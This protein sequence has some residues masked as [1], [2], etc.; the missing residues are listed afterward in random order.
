MDAVDRVRQD[1]RKKTGEIVLPRAVFMQH[2]QAHNGQIDFPIR[3]KC[4]ASWSLP[5]WSGGLG[6]EAAICTG[7]RLSIEPGKRR[8]LCIVW[9]K[10]RIF[11][12]PGEG[13]LLTLV[14]YTLWELYWKHELI[15]RKIP[16]FMGSARYTKTLNFTGFRFYCSLK[17]MILSD[18][19]VLSWITPLQFQ[20]FFDGQVSP[21]GDFFNWFAI[22]QHFTIRN[23]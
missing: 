10:S 23:R 3:P 12:V 21:I 20:H 17:K 15:N 7:G 16:N 8:D 22:L 4:R 18:I 9:R 1:Y 13:C 11:K 14:H 6:R 2:L 5:P 19:R